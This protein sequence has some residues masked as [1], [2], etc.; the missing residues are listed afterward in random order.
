[1]YSAILRM[2]ALRTCGIIQ[3]TDSVCAMTDQ[4]GRGRSEF[5]LPPITSPDLRYSHPI[6]DTIRYGTHPRGGRGVGKTRT[7]T[8]MRWLR[9]HALMQTGRREAFEALTLD[10][11]WRSANLDDETATNYFTPSGNANE[12]KHNKEGRITKAND[13]FLFFSSLSIRW[14][15]PKRTRRHPTIWDN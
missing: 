2:H 3:K 4:R 13:M 8:K 14:P 12:T 11:S 9:R 6:S 7:E 1:M 15:E 10:W 5:L